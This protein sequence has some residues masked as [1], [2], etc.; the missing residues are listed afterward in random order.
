MTWCYNFS[1]SATIGPL[2][3]IICSEIFD[4]KTR[5][6]GVSIATMTSFAFNTLIGQVTNV[7]IERIG[8]WRYYIVFCVCNFTNAIFFWLILPETAKLPL[9]DMNALFKAEPWLVPGT[10]S[11]KFNERK[12]LGNSL[13]IAAR[14]KQEN[15]GFVHEEDVRGV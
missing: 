13:E 5:S 15:I 6:K 14:T 11:R 4:T 10:Q 9:E 1:F 3:W 7:A 8:G 12:K 2:T